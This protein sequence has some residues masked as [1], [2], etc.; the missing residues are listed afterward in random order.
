MLLIFVLVGRSPGQIAISSTSVG[1]GYSTCKL[2]PEFHFV[3]NNKQ[4]I[5]ASYYL[6]NFNFVEFHPSKFVNIW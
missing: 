6:Y 3:C 1:S 2:F 4:A 5:Q